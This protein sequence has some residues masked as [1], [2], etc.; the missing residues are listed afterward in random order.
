MENPFLYEILEALKSSD[1]SEKIEHLTEAEKVL[2]TE[3][4][5]ES[6]VTYK[7]LELLGRFLPSLS[8]HLV[9]SLSNIYTLI[10]EHARSP[11]IL[12]DLAN[13][14]LAL[15]ELV[16]GSD[17]SEY[18][19]SLVNSM[20]VELLRYEDISSEQRDSVQA[21][22]M[23]STPKDIEPELSEI[24]KDAK[25]NDSSSI[26]RLME[27]FST[28][29]NIK[30]QF[31]AFGTGL[32]DLLSVLDGVSDRETLIKVYKFVEHFIFQYKYC[33]ELDGQEKNFILQDVK[34]LK[35]NEDAFY[36]ALSFTKVL[37]TRDVIL[38]QHLLNFIIRLWQLFPGHTYLLQDL[39][40]SVFIS[41]AQKGTEIYKSLAAKFLYFL[42]HSVTVSG[43][44]K[45]MLLAEEG[46]EPLFKHA[47]Y[48]ELGDQENLEL[49]D[50][51]KL[52]RLNIAAGFP[53]CAHIPANDTYYY[54]VEVAHPNSLLVWGFATETYDI[55]FSLT[56]L[57]VESEVI[58]AP[59][60]IQ[61]DS[62]PTIGV[63]L[64]ETP[65]LYKFEWDN[66]Y[67]WFREKHLRFK[68][69][70]LKPASDISLQI[71]T[72]KPISHYPSIIEVALEKGKVC[73]MG[74]WV[75]ENGI[76]IL[77]GNAK[78]HAEVQ[79]EDSL[80]NVIDD[81][82]RDHS[83]EYDEFNIGI[84][85]REPKYRPDLCQFG[86]ISLARDVDAIAYMVAST[87]SA[88][89]IIAVILDKHPRSA[90]IHEGR[91]LTSEDGKPLGDL[92]NKVDL[93]IGLGIA[94]L[95]SLFGPAMVVIGASSSSVLSITEKVKPLLPLNIWQHSVI[96]ES[97]YGQE[98]SLYA[99]CKLMS[100]YY[101][102][103]HTF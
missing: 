58:V 56:R 14:I 52:E 65:G 93:D 2:K 47:D 97:V 51:V 10:I 86:N 62:E 101:R 5:P 40:I 39:T 35:K 21:L 37:L 100:L 36:T 38:T 19:T 53:L 34:Y 73:D 90:I 66:A 55:G 64:I 82:C 50:K 6:L 49:I 48:D 15:S 29:R 92:S 94:N 63:R 9:V 74:V 4:S 77:V 61:C 59:Q 32:T 3:D 87:S 79:N 33:I 18:L 16:R 27:L 98:V 23:K 68:V 45:G 25:N 67:S 89:T 96:R 69:Y 72:Y 1:I 31:E 91:L 88:N 17:I 99:A 85:E 46:I 43:E 20:L 102:Y 81:F 83:E 95:L 78:Y 75:N 28:F 60:R 26:T 11:K 103:K 13:H 44:F 24:I 57:D 41:I 70:I 84:V 12:I 42:M 8:Y 76:D 54:V 22:L 71:S 80:K 7:A 30:E